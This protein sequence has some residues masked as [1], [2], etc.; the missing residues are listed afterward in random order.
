MPPRSHFSVL[1]TIALG[2]AVVVGCV[3]DPIAPAKPIGG[4]GTGG[5]A[6]SGGTGAGN[7]AGQVA[8]GAGAVP[9]GSASTGGATVASTSPLLPARIRRLTN[10]EYDA[11]VKALLGTS[12]TFAD[13]FPPDARQGIFSRGGYTLN[14]AQRVDPVLATQLSDA[15]VALVSEARQ[16]GRLTNMAPCAN[17]TSGGEACANTFIQS[18]G[19]KAYRRSLTPDEV[20]ALVGVYRIGVSSATYN[21]GIDLVVRAILQSA[22][23]LYVTEIGGGTPGSD[24]NITLTPDE[25]SSAL[26]YILTSGPPDDALLAVSKA[27]GMA[28]PNLREQQARRLLAQQSGQDVMV[29]M[30]REMFSLDQMAVT[31]K[32]ATAYPKFS[33]IKN[34]IVAESTDFVKAVLVNSTGTI[35]ELLGADWTVADSSLSALYG[36]TP[37]TGGHTSLTAAGRRGVMNQAAFLSVFAHAS[38]SGPVLRGVA[39][40]RQIA[41]MPLRSPTELNIDVTPPAFDATKTTRQRFTAHATDALCASC[42]ASIDSFGF[43]FEDYDGMGN[44]RP[45]VAGHPTENGLMVDTSAVISGTDFDGTYADS[46]ALALA[47]SKSAQ[48]RTCLARQLFR[49]STGRSDDSVKGSE[50]AFV[51]FWKQLSAA[52]QGSVL[53]TLVAYVKNPTFIQRR[54]Q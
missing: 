17:S 24:G 1:F 38:E 2:A 14:D 49:S 43:A 39:I 32:D 44:A 30:I 27:G 5:G 28:D 10:A 34:S 7:V 18:F 12:M 40:M 11:S 16:M 3:S 19:S 20:T 45:V 25:S 21:D 53:E 35:E 9:G 13:S 26:S 4:T 6:P 31:D 8:G 23:F 46:N 29:R 42:H 15:A 33:G 41:C 50:D 22:G 51:Q 36:G 52:Q 47:M 37:G 54:P 48:V